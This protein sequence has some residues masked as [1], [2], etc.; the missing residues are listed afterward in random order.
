ML[1]LYLSSPPRPSLPGTL[2]ELVRKSWLRGEDADTQV[3]RPWSVENMQVRRGQANPLMSSS[4]C[5][6]PCAQLSQLLQAPE[7]P[8]ATCALPAL[9]AGG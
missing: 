5:C 1:R 6:G 2:S 3:T 4:P 9:T 8:P 7:V